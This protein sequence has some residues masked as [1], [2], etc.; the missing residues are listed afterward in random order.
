MR[1]KAKYKEFLIDIANREL[2]IGTEN[3]TQQFCVSAKLG[4]HN[5][6]VLCWAYD[7]FVTH[8]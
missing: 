4:I 1:T 3:R 2:L 7:F 6:A 8:K 5:A